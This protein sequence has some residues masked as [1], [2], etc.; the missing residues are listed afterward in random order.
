MAK[1]IYQFK[2]TLRGLR[3]PIWR[4]V[5]VYDDLTFYE[6]H[7]VLQ[8]T[9]GWWDAHLHQ[10]ITPD[11]LFITDATTLSELGVDGWDEQKIRLKQ[12]FK[13]EG[14]KMVYEYD[15]GDSWEHDV[16]LE[17]ILPV[18]TAVTYPRCLKGKRACPPE[19]CGGV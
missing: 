12:L 16:L 13:Q 10:F 2:V 9:M 18:E 19:D 6:F 8:A 3:P 14:Q 5:Q 1:R 11:R 4:R 15:F 17:K 7:R